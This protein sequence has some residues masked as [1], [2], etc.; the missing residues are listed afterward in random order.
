MIESDQGILHLKLFE[1]H[2]LYVN[3]LKDLGILK[4]VNKTRLKDLFLNHFPGV[5]EQYDGRNTI[6]IFNKAMQNILKEH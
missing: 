5:Q 4:K 3:R 2:S 1:L 6:M